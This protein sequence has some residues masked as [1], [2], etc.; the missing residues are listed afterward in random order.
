MSTGIRARNDHGFYTINTDHRNA[1]L[2]KEVSVIDGSVT[3]PINTLGVPIIAVKGGAG[4]IKAVS[5]I[6]GICESVTIYTIA[7]ADKTDL[8]IYAPPV[9]RG[10]DNWGLSAYTDAGELA[11][12][13]TVDAMKIVDS[14]Y[15]EYAYHEGSSSGSLPPPVGWV[16][17]GGIDIGVGGPCRLRSY[18]SVDVFNGEWLV[19]GNGVC[20]SGGASD[21]YN[22]G[23]PILNHGNSTP[24]MGIK[25]RNLIMEV[26]RDLVVSH[27]HYGSS[28]GGIP[29]NWIYSFFNIH[30][31][32]ITLDD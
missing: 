27:H 13:S 6:G 5:V 19:I 8:R 11:Y 2:L 3:I 32:I 7:F 4:I 10:P 12:T 26:S 20:E 23:A 1:Q 21:W 25:S 15:I 16:D 29:N 24:A 14:S 30:M 9:E 18:R 31:N 17:I 22:G 28:Q